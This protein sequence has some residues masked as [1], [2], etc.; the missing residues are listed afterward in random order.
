MVSIDIASRILKHKKIVVIVF[1]VI[2]LISAI[3]Q[4]SVSVNYNMVD[5][6]PDD[7]RSTTAM[8]IMEEEFDGSVPNT[9]VMINDVTIQ[10]ALQAKEK[11]AAIDGVKDVT[12]L[13][14]AIDI[15]TPL[16]I[17]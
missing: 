17:A 12:W 10:E 3:V 9:R 11:L 1:M 13:D 5:Y 4:F 16:E 2:A 6:L 8:E 15:K 7:A 14:D